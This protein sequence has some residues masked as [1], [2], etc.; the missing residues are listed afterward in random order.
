MQQDERLIVKGN[1]GNIGNIMKQLPQNRFI[2]IHR[3]FVIASQ[4]IRSFNQSEVKIQG[5]KLPVGVSY[6][7]DLADNIT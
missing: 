6:R 2:R 1:I 7:E 4:Y 5:I 3:S